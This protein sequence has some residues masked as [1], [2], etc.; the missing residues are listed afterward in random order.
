MKGMYRWLARKYNTYERSWWR[1]IIVP[2]IVAAPP[3]FIG[4]SDNSA[5]IKAFFDGHENLKMICLFWPLILVLLNFMSHK[6]REFTPIAF[7]EVVTILELIDDIMGAKMERF[8]E[9]AVKALEVPT[10]AEEI[11]R[12]ITQPESQIRLAARGLWYYFN[13]TRS[14]DQVKIRVALAIVEGKHI[15]SFFCHIPDNH[16]P[17]SSVKSL[18][19]DCSGFSRAISGRKMIVISDILKEGQ[20]K[21]GNFVVTDPSRADEDGSM[22]CYPIEHRHLGTV[23]YVLSICASEKNYFKNADKEKY[24]FIISKFVE[25]MVLEHSLKILREKAR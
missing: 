18:Q 8:G 25:R 20:K 15:N 21:S 9:N 10:P 13:L 6:L 7:N 4:S 11:F 23:P 19:S 5:P 3:V 1:Y 12:R 24:E 17:R 16:G 2:L 22:I 14:S